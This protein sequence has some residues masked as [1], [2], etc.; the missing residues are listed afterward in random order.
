MFFPQ[1]FGGKNDT[2]NSFFFKNQAELI[3]NIQCSGSSPAQKL[4]LDK[5]H[6]RRNLQCFEIILPDLS[7]GQIEFWVM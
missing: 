7:E 4:S 5:A 6:T 3:V 1:N 2:G